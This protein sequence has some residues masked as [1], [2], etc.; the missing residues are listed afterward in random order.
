MNQRIIKAINTSVVERN[1]Q[2]LTLWIAQDDW[3]NYAKKYGA[4][5][6]SIKLANLIE[7]EHPRLSS[8]TF[9]VGGY[10]EKINAMYLAK[11]LVLQASEVGA[12]LAY[13]SLLEL[14]SSSDVVIYN[15]SLISGVDF[16]GKAELI[17]GIYFCDFGNLP[18]TVREN[19]NN[20]LIKLP[21]SISSS[22]KI[23]PPYTFLCQPMK[24]ILLSNDLSDANIK[25][26][27]GYVN[28]EF[29]I[30]NFLSLFA[31]NFA[32]CVELRWCILEDTTPLSGIIDIHSTQYLEVIKPTHYDSWNDIDAEQ[33]TN[34]FGK[35]LSMNEKIRLPLD[36]SLARLCQAMNTWNDTNKA[37]DLGIA[38][39]SILTKPD[40]NGELALQIKIIGSK[41]ASD[42]L[43]KRKEI[44]SLLNA[45]YS[46]RS[47]AVHDGILKDSYKVNGRGKL[48]PSII[49]DE[50]FPIL[51][52]CLVK[53]IEKNGL[54]KD[55]YEEL[56]FS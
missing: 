18:N 8:S 46:I 44:S 10:G 36:I 52:D 30:T 54:T 3:R 14:E 21:S 55:D 28:K 31:S 11:W 32:P 26:M 51:R 48:R 41:L 42:D 9:R 1:I 38:I 40:T 50:T 13:S 6:N 23:H 29:L 17:D 34:L 19:I 7:E 39:E 2:Q 20:K 24:S 35:Y 56:F 53:I 25:T 47:S 49:M 16:K 37:I 22:G 5:R 4:S 27:K 33:I 15:I 45:A 12:E 43:E